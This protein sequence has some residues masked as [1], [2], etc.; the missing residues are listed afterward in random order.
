MDFTD[1]IRRAFGRDGAL[2][3]DVVEELAQHA[4][5]MYERAR[6]DGESRDEALRRVDVQIALWA[7][8]AT[9]MARPARRTP[10]VEAPPASG[11]TWT[12]GLWHDVRYAGRLLRRQ[13]AFSLLVILTMALGI[14]ATT[15]LFSVSYGVLLK[16]LPWADADRLVVMKETRGGQAPRVG[17]VGFTNAVYHAWREDASTIEALAAW[18]SRTQILSGAGDPERIRLAAVS[19]SLFPLLGIQ[20]IAGT[21]FGAQDE[22]TPVVVLS[23]GL[24]RSRFGGSPDAVGRQVY[25]DGRAH[26]VV[27]VVP[28]AVAYPDRATRAWVPL[29][30]RPVRGDSLMMVSVIARLRPGV[31]PVQAGAEATARAA[32]APETPMTAAAFFG[33]AGRVEVVAQPLGDLLTADVRRPLLVLLAAVLLLFAVAIANL[34]GL[35]LARAESRRREMAIRATLGAGAARVTRQLLVENLLLGS[36]G[37]LAGLVIAAGLHRLVPAV[38][39]ADF[40]RVQDLVSGLEVIWFVAIISL[41][42]SVAVGMVPAVRARRLNLIASLSEDAVAAPAGAGRTRLGRM[43]LA[44]MVTQVAAACV[45]LVGA[46]LLG[47]SFLALVHAERGFEPSSALVA[48]VL[49]PTP[50]YT[51]ER[52]AAVVSGIL[53]R[54]RPVEGVTAASFTDGPPLGIFNLLSFTVDGREVST[55]SREVAPGYFEAM[56][57]RFVSGRGVADEERAA[58]RPVLVV[59][60]AFARQYLENERAPR[61]ITASLDPQY[62]QWEIVGIVEDVRHTGVTEAAVPEIYRARRA[63]APVWASPSLIVRTAGDPR[64]FVPSLHALARQQDPSLVFDSIMTLEDQVLTSLARPRLY[65]GLIA[66]FAGLA[67]I[68]AAVGL[69][70]VLS[71]TVAQRSRELA[72]RSAL[73]ARPAQLVGLVLRQGLAVAAAGVVLGLVA[74]SAL[75]QLIATML[76]GVPTR[77]PVTYVAVPAILLVVA[78]VACAVPAV[79]A[80]RVDPIGVLKGN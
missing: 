67:L 7:G 33:A 78:L 62:P 39:P 55:T 46:S 76:Y 16:P 36:T 73:G 4:R 50:S 25:I 53:E 32:A 40:P 18:S 21:L 70:G 54:L 24:W 47:R 75:V 65:A 30:V 20:P 52:R 8:D 59:N 74:A 57:M 29:E 5:A 1:R 60:R 51:P 63:D 15:T 77:D 31:T 6:A 69:F 56:G 41:L 37:G 10:A 68:V 14:G 44:I 9:L 22:A 48:N 80:A 35:Q 38:L 71:Y 66:G 34:C 58:G 28:D 23:E 13:W 3:D 2:D 11:G 45:L 27:A 19:A 42:A 61:T 79:R 64:A 49:L 17:A 43:R 12:T 26:T 72:V